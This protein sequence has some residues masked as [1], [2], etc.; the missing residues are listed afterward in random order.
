[1]KEEK[2]KH[3]FWGGHTGEKINNENENYYLRPFIKSSP[4][5]FECCFKTSSLPN[6]FWHVYKVVVRKLVYMGTMLEQT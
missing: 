4:C 6:V 2:Y 3:D 5:D 1:M